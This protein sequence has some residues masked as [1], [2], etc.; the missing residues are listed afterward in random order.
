MTW[1]VPCYTLGMVAEKV[2]ENCLVCGLSLMVPVLDIYALTVIR[3]RVRE[4]QDIEVSH[5]LQCL[6]TRELYNV[7]ALHP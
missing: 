2:G 5:A 4:Q 3:G 6:H 1:F 7:L